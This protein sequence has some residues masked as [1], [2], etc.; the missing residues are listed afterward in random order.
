M[1]LVVRGT[2]EK[3][4]ECFFKIFAE[5]WTVEVLVLTE[6]VPRLSHN[7]VNHIETRHLVLWS[8]LQE[9]K[10]G[11]GGYQMLEGVNIF[12]STS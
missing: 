4:S 3:I 2:D 10:K 9:T 8:T 11:L 5:P 7:G 1:Y 12:Q 6:L